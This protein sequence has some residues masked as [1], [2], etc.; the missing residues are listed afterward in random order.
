MLNFAAT[1]GIMESHARALAF[2]ELMLYRRGYR[3]GLHN[4]NHLEEYHSKHENVLRT[5]KWMEIVASQCAFAPICQTKLSEPAKQYLCLNLHQNS[6][7]KYCTL[8]HVT[9]PLHVFVFICSTPKLG[10]EILRVYQDWCSKF[11]QQ[12]N[13]GASGDH[14]VSKS[15]VATVNYIA[16]ILCKNKT[17]SAWSKLSEINK[18]NHIGLR[19]ELLLMNRQTFDLPKHFMALPVEILEKTSENEQLLDELQLKT[20]NLLSL[21]KQ[22]TTDPISVYYGMQPGWITRTLIYIDGVQHTEIR[23]VMTPNNRIGTEHSRSRKHSHTVANGTNSETED[24]G[25]G[26][27]NTDDEEAEEEDNDDDDESFGTGA[28]DDLMDTCMIDEN[29]DNNRGGDDF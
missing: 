18:S 15:T 11:H 17:P 3:E 13:G 20:G 5:L 7:S 27:E 4:I 22:R 23:I 16:L 6:T 26:Q 1:R 24:E 28:D 2:T 10:V 29:A 19:F 21:P 9:Q 12:R 25:C 14:H 8:S